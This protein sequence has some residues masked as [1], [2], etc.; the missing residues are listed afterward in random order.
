[1]KLETNKF[2]YPVLEREHT[3]A[4]R[5]YVIPDGTKL[6]SVTTILKH[7]ADNSH[8]DNWRKRI[9][10][11]KAIQIGNDAANLGSVMHKYIEYYILNQDIKR[12]TN[13]IHKMASSMAE[14][15]IRNGLTSVSAV[16]GI[17]AN[18]YY[19]GLYAGTIDLVG[20]H[21]GSLA[22]IDFKNSIKIKKIEWIEGYFQQGCAYALAH[23]ELFGTNINKISIMM[24]ARPTADGKP[25]EYKD[26]TIEGLEFQKF[27]DM[28]VKRLDSFYNSK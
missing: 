27:S 8:L 13:L 15:I 23:N 18:I 21:E 12:G 7:G 5:M 3:E 11:D 2:L 25:L 24:S 10:Y 1:M 28:W 6:P 14:N 19:P 20:V 26:F 22:I 17:E 16:H 9:G 4:G